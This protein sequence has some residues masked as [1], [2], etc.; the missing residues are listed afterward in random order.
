MLDELGIARS[1]DFIT[2]SGV[3]GHEKPSAAFFGEAVKAA[4]VRAERIVH[5]GDSL[6]HDVAG[7]EAAGMTPVL[8]DRH[9]RHVHAACL[10]VRTLGEL[11]L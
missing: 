2:I 11:G 9:D 5:V 1:L 8:I 7:A 3:C 4:G 6:H 10:R